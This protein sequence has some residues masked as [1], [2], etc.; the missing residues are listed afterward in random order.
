MDYSQICQ[1]WIYYI[2]NK[3]NGKMYI[4]RTNN[5]QR[6]KYEHFN[7][8]TNI[9]LQRAYK[10][11]GIE[12]FEM[13]TIVTFQA[14]NNGVLDKVL[15]ELEI[16]YIKRYDTFKNGYNLTIGGG[17]CSGFRMSEET[18]EKMR[19]AQLGHP[20]SDKVKETNRKIINDLQLWKLF[21]K[22]VL[23][24]SKTGEFIKRFNT[25][26]DAALELYNS[27]VTDATL[28]NI[29][30]SI[31]RTLKGNSCYTQRR[32]VYGYLWFSEEE[33]DGNIQQIGTPI[34]YYSKEGVLLASYNNIWEAEEK[35]GINR[36]EINTQCCSAARYTGQRK[37]RKNYWSRIAPT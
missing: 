9:L 17:G 22:P 13:N 10:K 25:I 16:Y 37:R 5:F 18:K 29:R 34:F 1:G 15:N 19:K 24:Y 4:G 27:G 6:R 12:N 20:S 14:I 21:E 3:I 33:H 11:Y 28:H 30:T 23:Q 36:R 35:T 8:E 7:I 2:K 26:K 32:T 31:S